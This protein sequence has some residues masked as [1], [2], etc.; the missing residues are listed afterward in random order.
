[1]GAVLD[2]WAQGAQPAGL[3]GVLESVMASTTR[4]NAWTPLAELTDHLAT[5]ARLP[6]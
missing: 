4:L 1:M 2:R 5:A 6:H 3:A